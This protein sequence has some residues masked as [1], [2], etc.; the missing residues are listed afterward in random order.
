MPAPSISCTPC[1]TSPLHDEYLGALPQVPMND[2]LINNLQIE[3]NSFHPEREQ[4]KNYHSEFYDKI[5]KRFKHFQNI[6]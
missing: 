1:I 5:K 2:A 3:T 6:L 4:E